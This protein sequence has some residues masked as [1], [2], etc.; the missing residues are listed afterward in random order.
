MWF[1]DNTRALGIL[2]WIVAIIQLAVGIL[3]LVLPLV[4]PDSFEEDVEYTFYLIVGLGQVVAALIYWWNADKVMKGKILGRINVLASYVA[5]VGVTSMIVY[6]CLGAAQVYVGVEVETSMMV[7]VGAIIVALIML[8]VSFKIAK[9]KKGLLKK[10][11]WVILV[12][13]FGVMLIR[14]VLPA[15]DYLTLIVSIAY[16]IISV[17][18][19]IL[20][21]SAEVRAAMGFKVKFIE[22]IE[23]GG[24]E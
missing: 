2:F 15:D 21:F 5:I 18:M 4:M 23:S 22:Y 8:L 16:L 20:L 17:F 14:S 24:V 13:S 12:I 11:I 19:L 1:F 3:I 9:G 10:I 7:V 6:G